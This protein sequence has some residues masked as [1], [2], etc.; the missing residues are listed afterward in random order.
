MVT[1]GRIVRPQG[2]RGEVVVAPETDFGDER[3]EPGA[4][5]HVQ[6]GDAIELLRVATSRAHDGRWVIGFD[7]VRSI[8]E[9][10][11]LRDRELRIPE[12]ELHA[13]GSNEFY[14]HDLV[15]CEVR[16]MTG[17][18][19]GRVRR[20]ELGTSTPMLVIGEREDAD[21]VL[22]PLVDAICRRIAV[23]E[24]VIEIDPPDGLIDVNRRPQAGE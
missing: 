1:V 12:A 8:D 18:S 19:V 20:V 9:A 23:E 24:R 3:F 2:N 11:A 7:G 10:E 15:G 5:L 4:T 21:D 16:T 22:V 17:V 14:V 6:R 13:L